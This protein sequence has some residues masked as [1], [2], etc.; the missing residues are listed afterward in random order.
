[1][2]VPKNLVPRNSCQ[3][4]EHRTQTT[5]LNV[6]AGDP[7]GSKTITAVEDEKRDKKKAEEDENTRTKGEKEEKKRKQKEESAA[8]RAAGRAER[9]EKGVSFFGITRWR[10]PPG[11]E[12][13]S[14]GGFGGGCGPPRIV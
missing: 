10:P 4:Q 14:A 8:E 11:I 1:L 7:G 9:S 3:R 13:A 5:N 2:L 12:I 6:A